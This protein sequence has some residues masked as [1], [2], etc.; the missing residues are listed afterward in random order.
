MQT[1]G[2][3]TVQV[4]PAPTLPSDLRTSSMLRDA[5]ASW[6]PALRDSLSFPSS[7]VN[8]QPTPRNIP[9]EQ[10]PQIHRGVC[11]KS[12]ILSSYIMLYGYQKFRR[13]QPPPCSYTAS[14]TRRHRNMKSQHVRVPN[15][16]ILKTH[17]VLAAAWKFSS[18]RMRYGIRYKFTNVSRHFAASIFRE[19]NEN[20]P[21]RNSVTVNGYLYKPIYTCP[22]H[23]LL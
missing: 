18:C 1:P 11:L 23:L 20:K 14:Q 5:N 10:R 15:V 21:R 9:E 2:Y 3:T 4:T 7:R 12:R 22:L 8:Y 16:Y 17:E 13:N 6:L 19:L